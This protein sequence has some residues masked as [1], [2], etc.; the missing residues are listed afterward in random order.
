MHQA[1]R[2]ISPLQNHLLAALSRADYERLLP[3]LEPVDLPLGWTA[4]GAGDLQN[5]LYFITAGIVSRSYVMGSGAAAEFS[6]TGREGAIGLATILGGKS[7]TNEMTVVIPGQAYRLRADW[8]EFETA[9]GGALQLMMLRYLMTVIAQI[10]QTA[11]CNRHHQVQQ[12]LCTLILTRLDSLP[13]N[14]LKIT[15]ELIAAELGV[16]RESVTDA[17]GKLQAAGLIRY[18][19]GRMEVLNRGRLEAQA[20]ECYSVLRGE[21]DRLFP[22]FD[23]DDQGNS[24]LPGTSQIFRRCKRINP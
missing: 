11:V 24:D 14:E 6:A 10:G 19:R 23:E 22:E 9:H 5:Y 13:T 20:C 4:Y 16:R 2:W 7:S 8:V 1:S 15:Q 17:A 21:R 18:S 3:H 12:Q